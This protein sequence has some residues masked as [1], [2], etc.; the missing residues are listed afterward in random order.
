L[1]LPDLSERAATKGPLILELYDAT[2]VVPPYA[3]ARSGKWG[4]IEIDIKSEE[5]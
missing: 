3:E 4:T 2:C 1:G 5:G